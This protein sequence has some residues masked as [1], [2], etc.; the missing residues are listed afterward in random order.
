DRVYEGFPNLGC[1]DCG[2]GVGAVLEAGM[3]TDIT[4]DR[5]VYTAHKADPKCSGSATGNECALGALV[6]PASAQK[7]ILKVCSS[8]ASSGDGY[9]ADGD[10][11]TVSF[12]LDTATDEGT[13]EVQ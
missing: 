7:G 13:I 5:R 10:Q 1:S 6:A 12:P 2:P 3:T 11:S 8:A 4:W 9:C